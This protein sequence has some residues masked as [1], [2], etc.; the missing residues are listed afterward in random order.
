MVPALC[1]SCLWGFV[2]FFLSL[3]FS[4]DLHLQSWAVQ[5]E[6]SQ[7]FL[8]YLTLESE[9]T[10]ICNISNHTPP[11]T[12]HHIPENVNPQQHCYDNLRLHEVSTVWYL[13]DSL[14]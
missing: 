13:Q 8:N 4:L 9:G 14:T 1:L 12:Q 2:I 5:E 7:T 11:V 6:S 10:I 3:R